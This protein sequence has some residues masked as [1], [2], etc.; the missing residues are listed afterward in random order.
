M[1]HHLAQE[2]ATAQGWTVTLAAHGSAGAPP[3]LG[4]RYQRLTIRAAN[5]IERRFGL[6]L[7]LPHPW[8]LLALRRAVRQADVVIQHDCVYLAHLVALWCVRPGTRAIVVKH[9]GTVRFSNW[10]GRTL[11][12]L[13]NR[14][15]FPFFLRKAD[16][17]VFVTQAKRDNFA[18]VEGVPAVIIPNGV[19]TRLFAPSS[20]ARD[21]SLLFAGRFVDKKGIHII[22]EL[23]R[24]LPQHRFVLAGFGPVDPRHWKLANIECHWSPDAE[25][26]AGL[27][28]RARAVVLPGETE[29]TPLVALE[30]L[31]CGTPVLIGDKGIA[32]DPALTRQLTMLPVNV[33][34]PVETAQLWA[35]RLEGAIDESRPE[36]RVIVTAYGTGRM[37]QDY[38]A[39]IATLD[40]T[41]RNANRRDPPGAG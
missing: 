29:G 20:V 34:R 9:T 38:R 2:L 3:A 8:D 40:P 26:L 7:L 5:G 22:R 27:Y 10:L 21:G 31:A 35:A 39:L 33:D 18:P 24:L 37:A 12:G 25:T 11:F 32:P 19:D 15:V 13:L 16:A 6:P 4:E 17:L 30:A 1:S 23:A 36:R 28:A 14:R 41:C